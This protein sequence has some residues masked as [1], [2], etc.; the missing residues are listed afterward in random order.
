MH[1]SADCHV[2]AWVWG[3]KTTIL[4]RYTPQ[5]YKLTIVLVCTIQHFIIDDDLD[6]CHDVEYTI[7][8][9]VRHHVFL[10]L[11]CSSSHDTYIVE[12]QQLITT[13]QSAVS[14]SNKT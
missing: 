11:I 13:I 9:L 4:C 12:H 5:I 7:I 1:E 6:T 3:N 8:Y 2:F 14:T 10:E